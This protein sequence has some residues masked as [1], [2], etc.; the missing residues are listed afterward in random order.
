LFLRV[1]KEGLGDVVCIA[2]SAPLSCRRCTA[3]EQPKLP[4]AQTMLKSRT[5]TAVVVEPVAVAD[6]KASMGP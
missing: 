2:G 6:K 1:G 5:K 3:R 4:A